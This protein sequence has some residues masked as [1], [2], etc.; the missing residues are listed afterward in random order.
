MND[1]QQ[2]IL[3]RLEELK[4]WQEQE[5]EKLTQKQSNQRKTLSDEQLKMIEFL[6]ITKTSSME[7]SLQT[8]MEQTN[9]ESENEYEDIILQDAISPARSDTDNSENSDAENE[10]QN[11]SLNAKAPQL[12][13]L[14]NQNIEMTEYPTEISDKPVIKRR[15]LKRGEGLEQRFKVHPDSFKLDKLPKYKFAGLRNHKFLKKTQK[16]SVTNPSVTN[17]PKVHK[18]SGNKRKNFPIRKSTD[19]EVPQNCK[20]VNNQPKITES[21]EAQEVEKKVNKWFKDFEKPVDLSTPRITKDLKKFPK[22]FCWAKILKA[23]NE[24]IDSPDLKNLMPNRIEN[25][26]S[27]KLDD[28]NLFELLEER[29]SSASFSSN[30]SSIY[31]LLEAMNVDAN[32]SPV[33]TIINPEDALIEKTSGINLNLEPHPQTLKNHHISI[34][35]S[36]TSNASNESEPNDEVSLSSIYIIKL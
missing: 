2:E 8:F 27:M 20:L 15:Y 24:C 30:S 13:P 9:L 28:L 31:R 14:K 36:I 19:L 18:D 4:K 35:D 12:S 23:N 25:K 1:S 11:V 17:E 29:I 26:D 10:I 34:D 22:A 32:E 21:A 3:L 7:Q 5:Q 6:G 33:K 16:S